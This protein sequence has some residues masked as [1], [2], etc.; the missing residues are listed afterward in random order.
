MK[1][2][3]VGIE[4]EGGWGSSCSGG[5]GADSV[6][7]SNISL[8]SRAG[9]FSRAEGRGGAPIAHSNPTWQYSAMHLQCNAIQC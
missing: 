4:V 3:Y 8:Q 1:M 2:F 6:C 9:G 5:D 7:G